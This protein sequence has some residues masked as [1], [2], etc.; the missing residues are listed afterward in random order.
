M[1]KHILIT[2]GTGYIGSHTAVRLL[3]DGHRVTI[4]DNLCNSSRDVVDRIAQAC[5]D[6]SKLAFEEL[7][8]CKHPLELT[9]LLKQADPSVTSVIHFAGLKAVGES[10]AKPL[11]YYN[12]NLLSTLHL[13]EAMKKSGV[14]ELVFSSSA[15]V[16]GHN[17]SNPESIKE[18]SSPLGATNPYGRT[19]L[20]LEEI[21]RDEARAAPEFWKS[22]VILRYF[23]PVGAHPSGLLGEDPRGTPN[24]LLPYVLQVASGKREEL[25]VFGSDYGTPDGTGV[26][27]YVHVCDLAEGHVCALFRGLGVE[28]FNLGTGEGTSVLSMVSLVEEVTRQKVPF[29]ICQRRPGDV[30]TAVCDPRKAGTKLGWKAKKTVKDAIVDAWSFELRKKKRIL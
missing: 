5:A 19:K 7:D 29:A 15:T 28:T 18:T 11:R 30:A 4:V 24:N 16:Y 12:N 14:R 20:W 21:L 3:Q 27:D 17:P 25:R 9:L 8:L 2:G 13:L 1:S 6:P 23:N 10:V 26:R 22:I